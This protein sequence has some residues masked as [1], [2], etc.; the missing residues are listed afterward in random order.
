MSARP[1]VVYLVGAGPGD[2]GLMTA[3]SLAL[4]ASADVVLYDRLI[5]PDA[6]ST[7]AREDAELVYVGKKPGLEKIRANEAQAEIE[8]LIVEH[9]RAGRSVV[10]L[11]G[12]DPFV[13]GRGG[14]EAEVLAGAGIDF[15]IVPGVT[16]GVAVPAYAGIPVTH[17]DDASAVAFVTGHEDPEKPETALDWDALARF[18][19]TLVLYMGVKNLP[20]IAESLAAAGRDPAEPAAAISAVLIPT[21]APSSSTLAELPEAVARPRASARRRSCS[22]ARSRRGARRSPG[23]SAVLFTA[24]VWSSPEPEHRRVVSPGRCASSAPR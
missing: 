16:A 17:R 6:R 8:A 4:I 22:S 18:P 15:E 20:L 7:G 2:P 11:K 21:S 3:R 1:G 9:A 14:E 23:S 13:F 24:S 12:G 19:G 10:R 5:G